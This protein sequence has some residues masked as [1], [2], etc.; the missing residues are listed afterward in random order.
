[1]QKKKKKKN[2]RHMCGVI[3]LEE[4]HATCFTRLLC[5]ASSVPEHCQTVPEACS[6]LLPVAQQAACSSCGTDA[7]IPVPILP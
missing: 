5:S 6:L 1:M 4:S 2:L 3:E 7:R